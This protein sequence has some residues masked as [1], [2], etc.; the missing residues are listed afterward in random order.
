MDSFDMG[1]HDNYVKCIMNE[2]QCERCEEKTKVI[3]NNEQRIEEYIA[4]IKKHSGLRQPKEVHISSTSIQT[5]V[6]E[7]V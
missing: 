4:Y 3:S 2:Y 1:D 6:V 7:V 5:E